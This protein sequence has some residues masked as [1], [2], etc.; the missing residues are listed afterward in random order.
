MRPSAFVSPSVSTLIGVQYALLWGVLCGVMRYIPYIG[1][2]FAALFPLVLSVAQFEG[3]LE[4]ALVCGL[5]VGLELVTANVFEPWLFGHS[6]GVSAV[7]LLIAAAFWAFLWGPV[8]LVLSCPLTVCLVVLGKYVPQLEFLAI[9]LG[10]EPPLDEDSTYYQR[11]SAHDQD[12][13]E[14]IVLDYI[15]DHGP[16]AVYDAL[17][18]PALVNAGRDLQRQGLDD[19]DVKFIHEATR[20]ILVTIEDARLERKTKEPV[21]AAGKNQHE[22]LTAVEILGVA[23]RG[24]PDELGLEM[25]RQ[26]LADESCQMTIAGKDVLASELLTMVEKRAPQAVCIAALPP[27]GL[28]H[29]RFLCKRLRPLP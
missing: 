3:W 17:L 21:A 19:A 6:I 14:D 16:D 5:F 22:D 28:T 12:E 15:K 25:L 13:A 4:P 2:P 27:G 29:A 24:E 23:A 18:I 9:L 11:L 7:A 20:E 1:S 10:D 8:G 26:M